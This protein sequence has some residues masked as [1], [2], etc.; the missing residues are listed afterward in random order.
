MFYLFNICLSSKVSDSYCSCLQIQ[1]E[2]HTYNM[3]QCHPHPGGFSDKSKPFHCSYFM[4]L[5]RKHGVSVSEGGHF[6]IRLTVEEFKQAVNM[7]TLWKPGMVIHVCHIKRKSIPNFVFPGGVRPPRPS[8]LTWDMR[9]ALELKA[10]GQAQPD[11]SDD[12]KTVLDGADDGRK[13]KRS[14][15]NTE[16]NIRN[17]R[18]V[19]P[20]SGEV[21]ETSSPISAVSSSSVKCD[22]MDM[23][24]L[25]ESQRE[26]SE[27]NLE[28]NFK[29]SENLANI[30]SH[31]GDSEVSSRCSPRTKT[32]LEAVAHASSSNEAENLAIEKIMSGPYVPHQAFP[33]ELDELEDDLE[34][35]NQVKDSSGN[36][37]G[38]PVESSKESEPAAQVT[39]RSGPGPSNGPYSNGGLEELEVK[40]YFFCCADYLYFPCYIFHYLVIFLVSFDSSLVTNAF[41]LDKIM[42]IFLHKRKKKNHGNY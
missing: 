41:F 33:G 14:D 40:I 3:L 24:K 36:V 5:Q 38:S 29:K 7:Y 25:V 35:R 32:L 9:R 18:S 22:I 2:R 8:K 34:L 10:S 28:D 37:K 19:V 17:V 20:S 6:D 21:L 26:I 13:R 27:N 16:N 39:S 1:I 42:A 30:P 4:G 11:K 12:S 23:N 15:D 31:N